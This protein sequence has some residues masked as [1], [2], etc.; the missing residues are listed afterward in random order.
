M[1]DQMFVF[2]CRDV[3]R[4]TFDYRR[5]ELQDAEQRK[6][7]QHVEACEKCQDYVDRVEGM[8]DAAAIQDFAESIDRDSLFDRIIAEAREPREDDSDIQQ[9][10]GPI[11]DREDAE[12]RQ[13]FDRDR[14][15]D[16]IT[17]DIDRGDAGSFNEKDGERGNVVRLGQYG[18]DKEE[19]QRSEEPPRPPRRSLAAYVVAAL[20]AGVVIGLALPFFFSEEPAAPTDELAHKEES[21]PARAPVDARRIDLVD[22]TAQPTPSKIDDVRVFGEPRANWSIRTQ[23]AKRRLDLT[24]GTVLVEFVPRGDRELEFVA[25]RFTVR[26][27]G[28]IFY[29][30]AEEDLV[31]VVTGSVEVDTP[32]GETVM[33]VDGQEWVDG[34]G[35]RQAA[36]TVREEAELHVDVER[37][38]IALREAR[39][40]ETRSAPPRD[41]PPEAPRPPMSPEVV[42]TPTEDLRRAADRA[43]RAKRYAV[44]AQYYER[45]VEE[46]SAADPAN[47]SLRLDL[48]RIYIR[49]LDQQQRAVLH[50]RRFVNDRPG[51]PATPSARSELCRIV[52]DAGIDEPLCE[53]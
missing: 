11:G 33:L 51:D 4:H 20:A 17:A 36:R 32:D 19:E 5:G 50:L 18:D 9:D 35:L 42:E 31:G 2:L 39:N 10:A 38:Q 49:H 28:T 29:A 6:F 24:A 7:E 46:L 21:E 12:D 26:V 40:A 16:R 14:M 53:P 3:R 41:R 1:T 52:T 47:A 37:H 8:L 25:D 22:L 43:L 15:F 23:G 45:M 27:T 30:S 44:A 48:A 34:V 13:Q